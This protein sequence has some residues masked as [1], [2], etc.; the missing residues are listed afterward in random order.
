MV[1]YPR[2]QPSESDTAMMLPMGPPPFMRMVRLASSSFMSSP[3]MLAAHSVRPSAAEAVGERP[4]I[5]LARSTMSRAVT[6]DIL[7]K[8]S[9]VTA[10]TISSISITSFR[11]DKQP[12][13]AGHGAVRPAR[14]R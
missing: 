3:S 1:T 4:C 7:T 11:F 6:A 8:P 9:A 14:A 13:G 5:C 10:L 2:V 12:V